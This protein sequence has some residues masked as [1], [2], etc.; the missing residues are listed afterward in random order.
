MIMKN[1]TEP[2]KTEVNCTL[3]IFRMVYMFAN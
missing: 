1:I 3:E 2:I